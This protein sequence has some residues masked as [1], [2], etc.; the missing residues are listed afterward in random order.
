MASAHRIWQFVREHALRDRPHVM[1]C[2]GK[3][4][5]IPAGM[6]ASQVWGAEYIREGKEVSSELQMRNMSFLMGTLGVKH[7]TSNWAVLRVR[8][9][10]IT[11][12][13]V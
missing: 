8:A 9:C 11:V 4:Y 10:A 2:L 6:Y 3:T 12:L 1:L 13:L 7:A 5:V